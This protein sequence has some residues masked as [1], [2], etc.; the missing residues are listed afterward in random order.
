MGQRVISSEGA[1]VPVSLPGRGGQLFEADDR[2]DMKI[3]SAVRENIQTIQ[4]E[5]EWPDALG[6]LADRVQMPLDHRREYRNVRVTKLRVV[7]HE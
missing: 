4:L 2:I 6:Q 5:V 1:Y 7:T 3:D